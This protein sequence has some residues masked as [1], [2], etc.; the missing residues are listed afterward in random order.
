MIYHFTDIEKLKNICIGDKIILDKQYL[1][2]PMLR[3]I[4]CLTYKLNDGIYDIV[5]I[6]YTIN[7]NGRYAPF[8]L[9]TCI[10][11]VLNNKKCVIHDL[12]LKTLNE[13]DEHKIA[14]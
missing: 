4:F 2:I 8:I 10:M 1:L 9:K 12:L 14:S 6:E 7:T 13:I 11:T 5:D 3:N